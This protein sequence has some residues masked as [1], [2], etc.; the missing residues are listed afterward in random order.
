MRM[1]SSTTLM[2]GLRRAKSIVKAMIVVWLFGL[3]AGMVNACVLSD[4]SHA[5]RYDSNATLLETD[6]DD[7]ARQAC[8]SFCD[9]DQG[10]AAQAKALDPP[11]ATPLLRAI[12][13]WHDAHAA[14]CTGAAWR[15][16]AAPP[17]PRAVS[18]VLLRLTL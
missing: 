3:A 4:S 17:P 6:E 8:L 14:Q 10:T 9:T 15:L 11:Q 18:I 2:T 1:N 13:A 16:A 12:G 7:A 5:A